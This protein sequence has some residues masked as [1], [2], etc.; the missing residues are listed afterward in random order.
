M[1]VTAWLLTICY[2]I[3]IENAKHSI[4][5]S[6][7]MP[8]E[9]KRFML[10]KYDQKERSGQLL[11]NDSYFTEKHE[12]TNKR[13]TTI[14]LNI[15]STS[16]TFIQT[17]FSPSYKSQFTMDFPIAFHYFHASVMTANLWMQ[18]LLIYCVC[19]DNDSMVAKFY[20]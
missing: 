14:E 13:W 7:I 1:S 16:R 15:W 18:W 5:T 12:Q 20:H 3:G 9:W 2:I 19:F 4:Y 8:L 17:I 10:Y 11:S 6:I